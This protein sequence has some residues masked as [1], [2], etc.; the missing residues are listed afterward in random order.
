VIGYRIRVISPSRDE[1]LVA[2]DQAIEH[3]DRRDTIPCLRVHPRIGAVTAEGV[4]YLFGPAIGHD[5][6]HSPESWKP[7]ASA[8]SYVATILGQLRRAGLVAFAGARPMYGGHAYVVT[9]EGDG[10]LRELEA[11]AA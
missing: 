8:I 5:W 3:Y 10:R 1:V 4:A 6:Y 9:E 2:L 7:S 11:G